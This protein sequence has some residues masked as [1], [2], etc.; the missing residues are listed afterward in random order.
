MYDDKAPTK[1]WSILQSDDDQLKTNNK[2][3]NDKLTAAHS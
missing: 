3:H 1:N 2:K